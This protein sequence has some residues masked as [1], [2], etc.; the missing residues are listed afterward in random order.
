MKKIAVISDIH[1]N[2]WALERVL[3]DIQKKGIN[4][5]INLGDH[6]NGPLKPKETFQL[7]K[8]TPMVSI[9]GN[10][11]RYIVENALRDKKDSPTMKYIYSQIDMEAV[12]W[13][14]SLPKTLLFNEFIFLTHGKLDIDD[15]YLIENITP[16]GIV[17]RENNELIS[18]VGHLPHKIILSAH[19]HVS[20]FI[21]LGNGQTIINS[22]S[23]G[24]PAY[25]DDLPYP[26]AMETCSPH[27]KYAILELENSDLINCRQISL[28]Y[29]WKFAKKEAIKNNRPDWAK[30]LES[31][32]A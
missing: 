26:H 31:G 19:S 3:E 14:K 11:D 25:T 30:W 9:A 29:D 21:D 6:L 10:G 13:L 27:A 2:I 23:V 5:I 20:R 7:I 4:T 32:R 16:E 24:L 8:E 15:K 12:N 1:G 28:K 18:I 17:V 22:G